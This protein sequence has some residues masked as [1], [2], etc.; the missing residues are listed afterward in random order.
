MEVACGHARVD[1]RWLRRLFAALSVAVAL[2]MT[3]PER[4]EID[5]TKEDPK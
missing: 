4:E 3:A 5:E 1:V 2:W